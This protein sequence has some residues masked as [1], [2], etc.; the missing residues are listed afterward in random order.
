MVEFI[1]CF[2]KFM[3]LV[4]LFQQL[5]SQNGFHL[6]NSHTFEHI[7]V[8]RTSSEIYTPYKGGG[9]SHTEMGH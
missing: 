6:L 5:S 3:I 7:L 9:T 2:T 1:E 4:A 8:I